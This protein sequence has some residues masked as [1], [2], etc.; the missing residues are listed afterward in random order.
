MHSQFSLLSGRKIEPWNTNLLSVVADW[1]CRY[2]TC[3]ATINW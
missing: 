2:D 1:N 3:S